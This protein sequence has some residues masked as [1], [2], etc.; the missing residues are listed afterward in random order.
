[1]ELL[2]KV[3]KAVRVTNEYYDDELLLL[4][5]STLVDLQT[6]GININKDKE[7]IELAVVMN[8]KALFSYDNK[9][10]QYQLDVYNNIKTKLNLISGGTNEV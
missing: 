3:R 4:I 2:E 1:M 8:V 7:L 9:D 5:N 10:N 6:S